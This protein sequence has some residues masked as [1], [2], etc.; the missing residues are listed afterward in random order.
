MFTFKY[1]TCVFFND[2]VIASEQAGAM[3]HI[4]EFPPLKYHLTYSSF[5][6]KENNFMNIFV[7][8]KRDGRV[9]GKSK[10]FQEVLADLKRQ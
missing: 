10:V 9:G 6:C 3:G 2:E 7:S 4:I 8:F 1:V 5:D